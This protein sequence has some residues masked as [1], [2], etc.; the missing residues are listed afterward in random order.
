MVRI[1][2]G[3]LFTES[4]CERSF[5]VE[6]RQYD[7]RPKLSPSSRSLPV[8]Q[9]QRSKPRWLLTT[10]KQRKDKGKTQRHRNRKETITGIE[11]A[12]R[13]AM[14]EAS[15]P[16]RASEARPRLNVFGFVPTPRNQLR[17]LQ[18]AERTQTFKNMIVRSQ[19]KE[20]RARGE[21]QG[22][23]RGLDGQL[24]GGKGWLWWRV[25]PAPGLRLTN[26]FGV[27]WAALATLLFS[28]GWVLG[29]LCTVKV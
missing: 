10:V 25:L 2:I 20:L 26:C 13:D 18:E 4:E 6:R 23:R 27:I 19:K 3:F 5:S 8:E 7:H 9:V 12:R 21:H 24:R 17:M 11:R 15:P 28:S 16:Q 29:R 1:S 22:L 14:R